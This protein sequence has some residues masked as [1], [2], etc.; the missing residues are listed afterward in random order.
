[1]RTWLGFVLLVLTTPAWAGQV[2]PALAGTW[3]TEET[4]IGTGTD[5]VASPIDAHVQLRTARV[6]RLRELV[7]APADT[8]DANGAGLASALES[9]T[10]SD[11]RVSVRDGAGHASSARALRDGPTLV[12]RKAHRVRLP[13]GED[14]LFEVDER[15]DL[16]A[17]GT[18]RVDTTAKVGTLVHTHRAIY[19]RVE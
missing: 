9:L 5:A 14:A 4:R 19:R 10:V 7:I 11:L 1:M 16:L 17:N 18:L 3:R 8:V 12:V 13:G 6:S 15:Y 2:T